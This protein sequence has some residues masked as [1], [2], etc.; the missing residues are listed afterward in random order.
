M[1]HGFLEELDA[2]RTVDDGKRTSGRRL[3]G[4]T[5]S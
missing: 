4:R 5:I 2:G 3:T 1:I